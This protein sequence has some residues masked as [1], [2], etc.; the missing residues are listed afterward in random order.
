VSGARGD[1]VV[2]GS[3]AIPQGRL[4]TPERRAEQSF[5]RTLFPLEAGP[6][7]GGRSALAMA[8]ATKAQAAAEHTLARDE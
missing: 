3:A 5:D 8:V 4:A 2:T 7:N 6:T 1:R